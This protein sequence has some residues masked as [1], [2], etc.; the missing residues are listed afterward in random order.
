MNIKHFVYRVEEM[1]R[2]KFPGY[3]LICEFLKEKKIDSF[4]LRR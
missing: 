1:L 4:S 3:E 2:E